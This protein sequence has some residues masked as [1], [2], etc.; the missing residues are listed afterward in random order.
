MISPVGR[1]RRLYLVG[2]M[3][4][5][6]TTIGRQLARQLGWTFVDLDREISLAEEMTIPEIFSQAGED[7]F[8]E[9]EIAYLRQTFERDEVVQGEVGRVMVLDEA[10]LRKIARPE[11][12]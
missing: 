6:K 10:A 11:K 8:R 2:F 9:L 5:G 12:T 3:A 4:V 1:W 7:R